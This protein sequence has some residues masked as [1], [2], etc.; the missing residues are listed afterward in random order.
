M[1]EKTLLEHWL[2]AKRIVR[3]TRERGEPEFP[4]GLGFVDRATGGMQR[5][6]IWVISGK[7]GSGKSALAMQL[8]RSFADKQHHSILFLSLE[9]R[10]WDLCLRMFCEMTGIDYSQLKLGTIEIPKEI[11]ATFQDYLAKIDFEI[12]ERGYEFG[13]VEKVITYYYK[14][15][16]P[17]IIFLDF[18]QL[19]DWKKYGDE[20][21]AI[22]EYIRKIK[23]LA[24]TMNIGFVVVS[25]IRRLPSGADYNRP[26]D[27]SDLKG[28]G[29]LEQLADKVIFIYRE[30]KD[31]V[32]LPNYYINL[33]KNRQGQT[34]LSQVE[35]EGKCYRFREMIQGTILNKAQNTFGGSIV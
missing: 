2:E 17:D 1:D 28:S 6:E 32:S 16:K 13:E 20:R 31:M 4:T 34:I 15:K 22:M 8:A 24:N 19:I 11:D 29:S 14:N 9:M 27:L 5:G 10:G 33:A 25:Q 21:I 3:E 12:I 30:F 26:P 7:T 18:I 35:F 23:E